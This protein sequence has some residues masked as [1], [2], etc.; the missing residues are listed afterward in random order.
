MSNT[1]IPGSLLKG[2]HMTYPAFGKIPRWHREVVLTEKLDG[3]NGL[4]A[5]C[6]PEENWSEGRTIPPRFRILP[7][8]TQVAAGSRKRWVNPQADNHGFAQ[9]VWDN[10]EELA[11]LGR[12][13]HYGEWYGKGVNRGYGLEG[14]HFALFNVAKYGDQ[15]DSDIAGSP[16]KPDCCEVVTVLS[17]CE[18]TELNDVLG[19]WLKMLEVEGSSHVPGYAR[20]EGIVLYHTAGNHLYKVTLEGDRAKTDQG[21]V[22]RPA[23]EQANIGLNPKSIAQQVLQDW[24]NKDFDPAKMTATFGTEKFETSTDNTQREFQVA[25]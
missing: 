4:V 6:P 19:Y 3:T 22:V 24:T 13:F 16:F 5:V 17:R 2:E 10:A 15:P 18:A 11:T 12:G 25:A 23:G 20:P 8:G 1:F 14:K 9:W 7:D 21:F